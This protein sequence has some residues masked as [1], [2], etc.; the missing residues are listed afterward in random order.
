MTL[1]TLARKIRSVIIT[2]RLNRQLGR[3]RRD[4]RLFVQA[5]HQSILGREPDD[6]ALEPL[7]ALLRQGTPRRVV[8]EVLLLTAF[9]DK[10]HALRCQMVRQL[11]P[12]EVVVDLGGA[13]STALEG[14]LL[15][16]TYPHAPREITIIDLPPDTRLGAEGFDHLERE[17]NQWK[18]FGATRVRYLHQSMTDL[19]GI[20]DE[21]VDLVWAGQSLEHITEAEARQTL[22]EVKR[23]LKAGGSFC[24]DTPNRE[25]TRRQFPRELIHVEHKIEYAS[26][27]LIKL[28]TEAGFEIV[29]IKGVAPMPRTARTGI[30]QPAE[31]RSDLPLSERPDISYIIYAHAKK[32]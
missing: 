32:P 7:L 22:R 21:S 2:A 9:T 12:A 31:V 25:I 29:E 23:V 16:M 18:T 14:S 5:A 10:L 3:H 24:L 28:L 27:Q 19:S 17:S 20:E 8:V 6:A 30:Y 11:P 4:D 1:A 13:C 26:P 15:N